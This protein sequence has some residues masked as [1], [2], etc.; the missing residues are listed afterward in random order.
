M[1]TTLRA[2]NALL[3]AS[4]LVALTLFTPTA[5]STDRGSKTP[6]VRITG[7]GNPTLPPYVRSAL[8]AKLDEIHAKQSV[9][10]ANVYGA[11]AIQA[12]TLAQQ[13]YLKASNTDSGDSFGYSV[14]ISGDTAVVGAPFENSS[15]SG[16]DGNQSDNSTGDA[17]AAYVFVWSGETWTQQAYLKAS[18]PWWDDWF[19]NSVAVSGDTIVVGAQFED[20]NATGVDGNQNNDSAT[21]SGAAYV[22]V[23]SGETWSQQAY[24]KASNTGAGDQFGIDVSVSGD[25]IAVGAFHEDSNAT[26]VNGN[27]SDNSAPRLRRRLCLRPEWRD[28][29]PAG[30]PQ[31]LQ[32]QKPMTGSVGRSGSRVTQS[33]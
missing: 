33:L 17:G 27:Q 8:E 1:T 23:R 10:A 15:A 7:N 30:L 22:F 20:S 6:E 25:T 29:V 2:L 11:N 28:V 21:N 14:A 24:L 26:G 4:I 12:P 19:G 9:I 18:N 5:Q 13:A 16:V 31:S 32:I 3:L